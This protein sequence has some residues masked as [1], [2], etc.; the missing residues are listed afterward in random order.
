[1]T[2]TQLPDDDEIPLGK[3]ISSLDSKIHDKRSDIDKLKDQIAD[4]ENE[5]SALEDERVQCLDMGDS[6]IERADILPLPAPSPGATLTGEP[7]GLAEARNKYLLLLFN[8]SLTML[9]DSARKENVAAAIARN[10]IR[11]MQETID[12]LKSRVQNYEELT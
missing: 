4:L 9:D 10:E 7:A 11:E 12:E 3:Q 8:I 5:I 2:N 6:E 1:M